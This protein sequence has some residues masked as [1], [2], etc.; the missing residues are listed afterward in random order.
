MKE[1]KLNFIDKKYLDIADILQ[2]P[3]RNDI[4]YDTYNSFPLKIESI[5]YGYLTLADGSISKMFVATDAPDQFKCNSLY[6]SSDGL[7]WMAIDFPMIEA[8]ATYNKMVIYNGSVY[9]LF[10][11]TIRKLYNFNFTDGTMEETVIDGDVYDIIIAK[12]KLY[13]LAHNGFYTIQEDDQLSELIPIAEDYPFER[14]IPSTS[15]ELIIMGMA[16]GYP[17]FILYD[18]NGPHAIFCTYACEIQTA[19]SYKD[20]IYCYTKDRKIVTVYKTNVVENTAYNIYEGYQWTGEVYYYRSN[21]WIAYMDF[22]DGQM[23]TFIAKSANGIDFD[24]DVRIPHGS[25]KDG[26]FAISC[27]DNMNDILCVGAGDVYTLVPS[28]NYFNYGNPVI[29]KNNSIHIPNDREITIDDFDDIDN[30]SKYNIHVYAC[31]LT[32][33][34]IDNQVKFDVSPRVIDNQIFFKIKEFDYGELDN[35]DLRL[36][37]MIYGLKD[38]C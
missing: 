34:V 5:D 25:D 15:D 38:V 22:E 17:V 4:K 9:V 7:N 20:H 36:Y 3:P 37:V 1:L 24:T 35:S 28:I 29:Y 16:E 26:K 8:T 2:K 23:Y 13:V 21:F 30:F 27:S 6:F 14:F 11:D 31:D 10:D 19:I 12:N 18:D 33:K 32:G